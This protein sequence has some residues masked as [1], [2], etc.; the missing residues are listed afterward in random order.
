MV[1]AC[2]DDVRNVCTF[3]PADDIRF[4]RDCLAVIHVSESE[5]REWLEQ[6]DNQK[7]IINMSYCASRAG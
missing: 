6:S 4:Y 1:N 5:V 3:A 7:K 2:G